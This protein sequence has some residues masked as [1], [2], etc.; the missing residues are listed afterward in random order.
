MDK[1]AITMFK[2]Y[3]G[4]QAGVPADLITGETTEEVIASAAALATFKRRYTESIL[5]PKTDK[6]T[7]REQFAEWFNGEQ[8]TEPAADP[9]PVNDNSYP[10][11]KDGG[12]PQNISFKRD[13]RET[14]AE[15]FNENAAFNP[16]A[17]HELW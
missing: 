6:L 9:A 8:G 13:P 14:F 4:E 1:E 17:D 7:A 11:V 2:N 12:T 15:W 16:F 3:V 10:T 5:P